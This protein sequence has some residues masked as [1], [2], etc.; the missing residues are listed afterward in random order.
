LPPESKAARPSVATIEE[1]A[2]QVVDGPAIYR[3]WRQDA[4]EHDEA[5]IMTIHAA[6]GERR[7]AAPAIPEITKT[8]RTIGQRLKAA[9]FLDQHHGMSDGIRIAAPFAAERKSK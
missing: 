9:N 6:A 4:V 2:E 8:L 7:R 3:K 1:S 5:A